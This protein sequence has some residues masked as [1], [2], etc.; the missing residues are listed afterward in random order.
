M[1]VRNVTNAL[2]EALGRIPVESDIESLSHA[3]ID[4]A[5]LQTVLKDPKSFVKAAGLKTSEES[6]VQVT[7]KR[8]ALRAGHT[9]TQASRVIV[10]VVK[11]RNCDADIIV[12]VTR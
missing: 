10:I 4:M 6:Q 2:T 12:I 11:Y 5:H 7:V 3:E 1:E 9:E 8:R